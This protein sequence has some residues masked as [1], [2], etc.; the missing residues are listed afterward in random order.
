[1]RNLQVTHC[2][3][4]SDVVNLACAATLKDSKNST[5]VV[6][7]VQPFPFLPTVSVNRDGFAIQS[8]GNHERQK[9][10]WKLKGT[11]IVAG[12]RNDCGHAV[13]THEREH[14]QVCS[15]FAG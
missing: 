4:C 5:A 14:E 1:M 10:L 6:F 2:C 9:F 12:S 8:P 11:V 7:H 3:S 13:G 15:G